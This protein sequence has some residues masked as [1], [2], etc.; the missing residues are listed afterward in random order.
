MIVHAKILGAL[1]ALESKLS[2]QHQ[3]SPDCFLFFVFLHRYIITTYE[4]YDKRECLKAC[5]IDTYA[6]F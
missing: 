2:E 3:K 4:L 1:M 6:I 5:A